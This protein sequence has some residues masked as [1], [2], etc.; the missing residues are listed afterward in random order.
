MPDLRTERLT[1]TPLTLERM[2]ALLRGKADLERLI[3]VYVPEEWPGPD[4]SDALPVMADMLALAQNGSDWGP[5]LVVHRD[6]RVVIGDAGFMGPPDASGSVELG[7]SIV[8]AYRR[9][10]YAVEAARA[11]LEW[12]LA[13]PGVIRVG[14]ECFPDNAASIRVLEKIGMSL[15]E[16]G[17][18]EEDQRQDGQMLYWERRA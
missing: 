12:A 3:G 6:D 18:Q 15:V 16:Q 5:S 1:L 10:G 8:P 11:L 7:Y 13:R 14:A 9:Q 2:R 17:D 4:L